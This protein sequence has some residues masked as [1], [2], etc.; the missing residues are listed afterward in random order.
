MSDVFV[1]VVAVVVCGT[2]SSSRNCCSNCSSLVGVE[3]LVVNA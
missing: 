2:S 1:V 3:M